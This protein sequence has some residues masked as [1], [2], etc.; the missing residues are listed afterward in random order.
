MSNIKHQH[1]EAFEASASSD[2]AAAR[3]EW[4]APAV[5]RLDAGGAEVGPNPINPEQ[6]AWG[7]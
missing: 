3:Q 2:A 7:S 1:R 6:L 4:T 5:F